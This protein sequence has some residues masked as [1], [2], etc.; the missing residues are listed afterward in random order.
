[1]FKISSGPS[2]I[3]ET[4]S[5]WEEEHTHATRCRGCNTWR[6]DV[7]YAPIDAVLTKR[8]KYL[9]S[10]TG[11]F[12]I[13]H[14]ELAISLLAYSRGA[15]I[16][17]V[18]LAGSKVVLDD[19]VTVYSIN[20]EWL[21]TNRGRYSRHSQCWLCGNIVKRNGWAHPVIVKRYLDDRWLYF[22]SN[23][24]AYVDVRLIERES[25]R[26]RFPKLRF[27]PVPVV[28]EPLDGATLPGD[29]GWTGKLN[30]VP[31]P[32]PPSHRPERGIGLWL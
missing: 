19:L 32:D 30:Y 18:R 28:P 20:K 5:A 13:W 12:K 4:D 27:Y 6:R 11:I 7:P 24:D 31:G 2:A 29:P 14:K 9:T 10:T 15:M 25:L 16:G 17:S 23:T 8:P 26:E 21:Q 1:M 22:D 3:A